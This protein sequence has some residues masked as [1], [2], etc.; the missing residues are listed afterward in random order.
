[1][2]KL[3]IL[4]V[5]F[6]TMASSCSKEDCENCDTGTV[7]LIFKGLFNGETLIFNETEEYFDGMAMR[8]TNLV[9]Y[10]SD[11][12]LLSADGSDYELSDIELVDFQ[13][14]SFDAALAADGLNFSFNNVP[15]GDYTGVKFGLG[16][17]PS[18]NA[19]VPSDFTSDSPLSD[20]GNHW[21]AWDSFIFIKVEG[22]TDPDGDGQ[23]FEG[24][25]LYHTGGNDMY[26]SASFTKGIKVVAE[27][28]T[29]INF[30]LET[31]DV[32][33]DSSTNQDIVNNNVSH[34]TPNDAN[35]IGISN[36]IT[37]NFV[38]AISIK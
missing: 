13:N 22:R 28:A 32:F 20:S 4:A 14:I 29:P 3:L 26:K 31:L 38:N 34:T 37:D 9:F 12:T 1:M 16:V 11:L 15:V 27:A 7:N 5:I 10:I 33:G 21:T 17:N 36:F 25:F 30:E 8:M 19:Q 18:L 35:S 24:S 6:A 2:K 23:Q